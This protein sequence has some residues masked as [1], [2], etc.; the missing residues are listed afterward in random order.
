MHEITVPKLNSND[1]SYVLV[2]WLASDGEE[3]APDSPVAVIE[4]S[5]TAE[6]LVADEGGILQQVVGVNAECGIGAVIARLFPTERA[7]AE[8]L[9]CEQ[10]GQAVGPPA[11]DVVITKSA[12]EAA[13]E[14]GVDLAGLPAL[15]RKVIKRSDIEAFAAAQQ[16][17]KH[18]GSQQEPGPGDVRLSAAQQ[19]VGQVVTRSHQDIPAAFMAIKVPVDAALE[20]QADLAARS[21]LIV[22]LPELLIKAVAGLRER[23]PLFFG[24]YSRGGTVSLVPGAHAGIT[25]DLGRGLY[26]PVLGRADTK[27]LAEISD[28]LTDFRISALRGS[29][30]ESELTGGNIT[31]SLSNDPDILLATPI[32]FPGQACMLCLCSTQEELYQADSGEIVIRRYVHLGITYDH[33]IVNGRDATLFLQELKCTLAEP[34]SLSLLAGL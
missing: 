32:I 11:T 7:R 13:A 1:Q 29:F 10:R 12:R 6:E 34:G 31:I 17:A 5:K 3:L 25:L 9:A 8:Y 23:F 26:I 28:I 16:E 2:E 20:L 15:G 14:L 22:G 33:R 24:G 19:A 30:R 18:E 4:T 21:Q 27:S